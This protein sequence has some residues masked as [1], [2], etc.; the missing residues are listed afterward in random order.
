MRELDR[1]DTGL[2]VT[3][4]KA[5]V[6]AA[7]NVIT[8][9]ARQL[10]PTGEPADHPDGPRLRDMIGIAVRE[11]SGDRVL[12]LTGPER[13]GTHGDLG[14]LVEDGHREVLWAKR[15]GRMVPPHPFLRPAF[16]ETEGEQQAAMVRAAKQTMQDLGL[17]SS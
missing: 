15:T 17:G 16:D 9:R 10:C 1:I 11:Y 7:A 13:Q 3:L 6:T 2:K 4:A 12:A 5:C 14:R 8:A